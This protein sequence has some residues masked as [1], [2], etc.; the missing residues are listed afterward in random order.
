MVTAVIADDHRL[1][2]EAVRVVLEER[3]GVKV[4][5]EASDGRQA[6]ELAAELKPDIMLMD[7]TMPLLNG[8]EATRR[9]TANSPD[10]KV[11]CMTMQ[12]HRKYVARMLQAGASGYFLKDDGLE[13]LGHAIRAVLGGKT[14]LSEGVADL[15]IEDYVDKLDGRGR[16]LGSP[17]TGREREVLQLVAEGYTTKRIAEELHIAIKTVE[18]HRKSIMDKLNLGSIADLTKYAI[19]EGIIDA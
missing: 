1:V 3:L 17:L 9:I 15:V 2:R 13:E 18:S 14:F 5:G 6:V 12:N 4:V 10:T 16:P 8:V 19:R 7:I 11:L